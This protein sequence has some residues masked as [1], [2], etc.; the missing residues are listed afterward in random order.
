MSFVGNQQAA[1]KSG[2]DKATQKFDR[3]LSTDAG[4]YLWSREVGAIEEHLKYLPGPHVLGLGTEVS[5]ASAGKLAADRDFPYLYVVGSEK[6]EGL[7]MCA[8]TSEALPFETDSM[9]SILAIHSLEFCE[10][11]DQALREAK[12]VLQPEGYMLITG[13]NTISPGYW[14]IGKWALRGS[15]YPKTIWHPRLADWL[16]LLEFEIVAS[17][18]FCYAPTS[19]GHKMPGASQR[20]EKAGNRWW[21]MLGAG[22]V[23]VARN[24]MLG[25]KL[26][27]R[28]LSKFLAR[29]KVVITPTSSSTHRSCHDSY[30]SDH[31]GN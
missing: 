19:I 1:S 13:F 10:R 24:T 28:T 25:R 3:W 2:V 16:R 15:R 14:G 7:C 11:P 9:S 20:F 8:A 17:S 22:Y 5:A 29:G 30:S 12:R 4:Q 6:T 23:L 27:G 18:M 26:V 21:P 31:Q